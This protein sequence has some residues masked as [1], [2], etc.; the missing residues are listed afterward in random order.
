MINVVFI[1][2]TVRIGCTTES[3]G[4]CCKGCKGCWLCWSRLGSPLYT[5]I[6]III[7]QLVIL[8]DCGFGFTPYRYSG[9]YNGRRSAV[10]LYG[11]EHSTAGGAPSDRDDN[12]NRSCG[13]AAQGLHKYIHHS[14]E[15]KRSPLSRLHLFVYSF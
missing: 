2:A 4:Y 1:L 10:L 8:I 5:V 15:F 7:H 6:Y 13:M 9:V 3:M 12:R 11:D 14:Y